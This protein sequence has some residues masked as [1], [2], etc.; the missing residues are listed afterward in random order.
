MPITINQNH[1]HVL[2]LSVSDANDVRKLILQSETAVISLHNYH[3]QQLS[4]LKLLTDFELAG[5]I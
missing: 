2:Y 1:F 3:N 5:N 4:K